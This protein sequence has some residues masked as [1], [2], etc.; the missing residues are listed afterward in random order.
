MLSS[1]DSLDSEKYVGTVTV[2]VADVVRFFT[3][4]AQASFQSKDQRNLASQAGF[5]FVISDM[6]CLGRIGKVVEAGFGIRNATLPIIPSGAAF[7]LVDILGTEQRAALF[8]RR[9]RREK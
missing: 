9:T 1:I 2:T 5:F 6:R 8:P 4:G 3:R 7:A